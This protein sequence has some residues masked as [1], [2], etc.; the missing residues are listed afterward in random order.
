MKKSFFPRLLATSAAA[1]ALLAAPSA[2]AA[3]GTLTAIGGVTMQWDLATNW[4]GSIIADGAGFTANINSDIAVNRILAVTSNRTIGIL[5]IGDPSGSN[6]FTIS[7]NATANA[8]L[9]LDG[10]GSNAQINGLTSS[11]A[12]TISAKLGLNSSLDISNNATSGTGLMTFSGSISSNTAGTKTITNSGASNVSFTTGVISD[13]P[14]GNVA[15]VQ[16]SAT[17]TLTLSGVNTFSGGVLVKQGA[18]SLGNVAGAGTGV[19]T[20]GDTGGSANVNLSSGAG[21]IANDIT[22][23]S[24]STGNTI[25][26]YN[27]GSSATVYTGNISL[28]NNLTVSANG[29]GSIRLGGNLSGSKV[30][31]VAAATSTANL[32]IDG[33]NNTYN[34]GTILNS[35]NLKVGNNSALG[36]GTLTINGGGLSSNSTGARTLQNN[37]IVGGDFALGLA[38]TGTGV[39]TLNGTMDLGNAMRSI[40]VNSPGSNATISGVISNG[41]ITLAGGNLTLSNN[42]NSYAG[43]TVLNSGTLNLAGNRTLG[44]GNLTING[45]SLNNTSGGALTMATTNPITLDGNVTFVGSAAL[46]MNG[47]IS[48]GTAA[49]TTRQIVISANTLT[50]GGNI[51]DG[52]NAKSLTVNLA[53]AN[54]SL[55]LN[56]NNT[57]SGGLTLIGGS[58]AIKAGSN[59]AFGTG[60]ITFS[61]NTTV[62]FS[63]SAFTLANDII[64]NNTAESGSNMGTSTLTLTGNLS[65]TGSMA[66]NGFTTGKLKLSGNN[67]A[68]TGNYRNSGGNTLQLGSVNALGSGT[69]LTFGD[70]INMGVLESTVDISGGSGISQNML[71]G[72]TGVGGVLAGN[73][74]WTQPEFKTTSDMKLSGVVSGPVGIGFIKSGA[75]NLTLSNANTYGGVTSINAGTVKV[76]NA[77]ALGFGGSSGSTN[78]GV[79]VASGA[80]LDLNG[81][82]GVN[83]AITLNGTGVGANGALIN[84][85]AAVTLGTTGISAVSVTANGIGSG[86]S[87]APTVT[88]NGT[89]SGAVATASLGLTAASFTIASQTNPIW[90]VGDKFTISGGGGNGSVFRVDSLVG[91]NGTTGGIGAYSLLKPGDGYT[92]AP[93]TLS[94][95]DNAAGAPSATITGNANNFTVGSIII[96]N[97]GTGYTGTPV[98][99]FDGSA[100]TATAVLGSVILAGN[101]SIGGTG[102]ITINSVIS[103]SGGARTLTKVGANTV[104]LAAANTY[105]G[106][107]SITA[108]TLTLGNAAAL[109]TGTLSINGTATSTL[110]VTSDLTITNN[111]NANGDWTFAGSHDLTINGDF[112]LNGNRIT[113]VT[114]GNLTLGGNRTSSVA[115]TQL[116]KA[117]AGTLILGQ[118]AG[119][120]MTSSTTVL[121]GT[122]RSGANDAIA[123]AALAI[124]GN[125]GGTAAFDIN[126]HTNTINNITLGGSNST[127]TSV[128]NIIDSAGGGLITMGGDVTYNGTGSPQGSVIS[129]NLNLALTP[130]TFNVDDSPTAV[131]D[132]TV[133]GVISNGGVGGRLI[134]AGAGTLVLSGTNTFTSNA[135]VNAGTLLIN[136]STSNSSGVVVNSGGTLGGNGTVGGDTSI[137]SGGNLAPGNS[138]GVLSFTGNLTLAG[139]TTMQIDGITARG[140]DFDGINVGLKLTYGGDL[141]F[142]FGLGALGNTTINL[143]QFTTREVGSVFASVNSTGFYSGTWTSSA[144]IWTF[145]DGTQTLTFD[146]F[147]GDLGIV[148]VPEPAAWILAAFGLTTA[149]VFRRRRRD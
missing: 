132:L 2:F 118:A 135:T 130:H 66:V 139:T 53:A 142:V 19:I 20:L 85:G 37:I 131:N 87:A 76:E 50:L 51:T 23:A 98:V 129:A 33:V 29:T 101:S 63:G 100:S 35:G 44:S 38:A 95:F 42:N 74:T 103:E 3:N 36:T 39:V 113:T 61:A 26:I 121:G 21:T 125:L 86:L 31:T 49:G 128:N 12:T 134:K 32:T 84:S 136:G 78:S 73:T 72:Q 110:D 119:A 145:T 97:A 90:Q 57:F 102:D 147:S 4:S 92:S 104:V 138:P 140:T 1:L 94:R 79:N 149:V 15:V 22:V 30:L 108:G 34:G 59:N 58:G 25:A 148:A 6:T 8:T 126:G 18:L 77:A 68:W 17:S 111:V 99:E 124:K 45:G 127:A 56:G 89:G 47:A 9:T 137:A 106:N 82:S 109:G 123:A 116:F 114:G 141:N 62:G 28:S 52:T 143:F 24:G 11:N 7:T 14:A 60:V 40:T 55:F 133:S 112:A 96:S 46:T 65:G 120:N 81:T 93:T 69:T 75:G 70:G 48:L 67:T 91:G 41:G 88:I 71:L 83:K 80:A 146:Q 16:N 27:T 115:L 43:G 144:D 13:G 5:N 10:N 117:G 122:L 105:T 54:S 64:F 107:T